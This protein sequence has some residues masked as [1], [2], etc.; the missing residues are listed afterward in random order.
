MRFSFNAMKFGTELALS[1]I[2]NEKEKVGSALESWN[3][4]CLQYG[5]PATP[6]GAARGVYNINRALIALG[7]E[8]GIMMYSNVFSKRRHDFAGELALVSW[9][10]A[11]IM[12]DI[13][14]I[15][16]YILLFSTRLSAPTLHLALISRS[17]SLHRVQRWSVWTMAPPKTSKCRKSFTRRAAMLGTTAAMCEAKKTSLKCWLQSRKTSVTSRCISTATDSQT[18]QP[19]TLPRETSSIV[20]SQPTSS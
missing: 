17:S 2:T 3:M 11:E 19:P 10:C 16:T 1:V 5:I 18:R 7:Q 15:N 12:F 13:L 6:F 8:M 20:Q 14:T 4:F 9:T